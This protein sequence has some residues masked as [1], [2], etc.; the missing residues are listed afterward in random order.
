MLSN[1]VFALRHGFHFSGRRVVPIRG[2]MRIAAPRRRSVDALLD[3]LERLTC[4]RQELR[5]AAAVPERLE[6][7]R[8]AIVQAQWELSYALIDRYLGVRR[9]A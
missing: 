6:Q 1:A 7:N 9:A 2:V 8:V 3:R 4:E 5:A